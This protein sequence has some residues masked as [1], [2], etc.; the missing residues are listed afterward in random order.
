MKSGWTVTRVLTEFLCFIIY[1]NFATMLL[2]RAHID[3]SNFASLTMT[4]VVSGKV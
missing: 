3:E 1:L 4:W 2:Y